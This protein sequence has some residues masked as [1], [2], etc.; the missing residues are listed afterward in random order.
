MSATRIAD[1]GRRITGWHV[2]AALVL[3]F[4]VIFAMNAAL[5]YYALSSFPGLEVASS[6]KA[7]Q[8]FENDVEAARAQAARGWS[9]EETAVLT[10]EGARIEARFLDRDGAPVVGL[11]VTARL[12]H[13]ATTRFD[14]SVVLEPEGMG[15]YAG[16]AVGTLPGKWTL[17]LSAEKDGERLFLSRNDLM[18]AE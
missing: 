9:V 2:L 7:G 3:F 14:G 13:N 6:Y 5:I 16:V 8:E 17:V 11:L 15:R 18:L 10:G 1:H 4:A 12:L